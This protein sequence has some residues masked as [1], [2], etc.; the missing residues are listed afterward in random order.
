VSCWNTRK[1]AS[2]SCNFVLGLL[3]G[4][5]ASVD[6]ARLRIVAAA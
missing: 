3:T 6:V 5:E 1:Q 2:S 4:A